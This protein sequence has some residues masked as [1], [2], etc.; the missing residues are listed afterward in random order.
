MPEPAVVVISL[1]FSPSSTYSEAV[2]AKSSSLADGAEPASIAEA[3][4][5]IQAMP[6]DSR[7]PVMIDSSLCGI[8]IWRT[9]AS[10]RT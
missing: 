8:T 1:I 9:Q 3:T 4:I 10:R 7:M 2:L 5:A 6:I